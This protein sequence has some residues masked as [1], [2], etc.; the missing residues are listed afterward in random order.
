MATVNRAEPVWDDIVV[1]G[2][3]SGC[4]LAARL[5]ERPDRR[6][7]LL[8]AGRGR[9]PDGDRPVLSGAN[10][11]LTARVG[12]AGPQGRSCPYPVGRG[13]GGSSAVNGALALRGLPGDF[14]GWAAAGNDAWGWEQVLPVYAALEADADF[15]GPGHGTHGPLPIRRTPAAEL[16]PLAGAFLR[17]AAALGLPGAAD[18]NSSEGAVGAGPVPL[19][20]VGRRR[21]S[22]ADAYLRPALDRPNLTV[23]TDCEVRDVRIAG[24]RVTGVNAVRAGT[25]VTPRAGRVTLT[26]G[27][28]NTAC[29]LL[30]SGIG[31]AGELAAQGIRPVADLPGVGRGLTDHPIVALWAVT[32]PDGTDPDQPMH[33]VLARV[34]S[35]GAAVPDLNLTLVNTLAGLEVPGAAAVLRGRPAMSLH[36]TL[37]RPRSRGGVTLRDGKPVITLRLATDPDD[38]TALMSGIRRVWELAG[39]PELAGRLDRV[40]M[41]TDRMI[42]TDTL[43]RR[44]VT[45]FVAPAW[46]PVG[47]ARMGPDGDAGAVVDQRLAVRGVRGL[48]VADASVMPAMPSAPTN[49]TCLMIA[50]R[51]AAWMC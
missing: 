29:L 14:D 2:G 25:P 17:A 11:D 39:H 51:A 40:L 50:E 7:L 32:A 21:V 8:E 16:V 10:W 38:V 3:S 45:S 43:L 4:V 13:L 19:N 15:K 47:T 34:S 36:A 33:Q 44:A 23:W 24:G 46:H 26:A 1:G 20:A 37:L 48:H 6:V 18:L 30:R 28:V 5:A 9:T 31:P 42:G 27:A 49:L 41:W 12:D 35:T 22:A